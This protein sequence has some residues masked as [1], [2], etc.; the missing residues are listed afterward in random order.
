[1]ATLDNK[2]ASAVYL[3][4]I[5]M[6]NA[7]KRT[8]HLALNG[9]RGVQ[10]EGEFYVVIGGEIAPY[11]KYTNENW[12]K[13]EKPLKGKI[14]PHEGWIEDSLQ[15]AMPV[16]KPMYAGAMTEEEMYKLI[17]KA[18]KDVRSSTKSILEQIQKRHDKLVQQM[19]KKLSLGG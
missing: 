7:P 5:L 14:N 17:G 3:A 8:L 12:D 4:Q 9:I 1:M 18:K 10:E 19:K 13:F 6:K 16:F 2:R 15:E 11:A